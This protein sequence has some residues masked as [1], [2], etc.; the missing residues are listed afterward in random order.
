MAKNSGS[1]KKKRLLKVAG[2]C[3]LAAA[4]V[5]LPVI[6]YQVDSSHRKSLESQK[7]IYRCISE[8]LNI[9]EPNVLTAADFEK[10]E[11][12]QII[13]NGITTTK[14]LLKLKNLKLIDFKYGPSPKLNINIDYEPLAKAS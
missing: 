1:R 14:P 7:Y 5:L 8:Q 2:L 13:L 6:S 3:V 11:E 10:L 12:L 9:K 4:A